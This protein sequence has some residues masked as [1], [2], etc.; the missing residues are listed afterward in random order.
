MSNSILQKV[1][2]NPFLKWAGGK[3]RLIPQ[4]Q[5]Y[6]P[7]KTEYKNYFEPFLGGGSVF[8][9]LQPKSAFLTDINQQLIETYCCVKENVEDLIK[10]LE[11]HQ[12]KHNDHKC[13]EHYYY[14]IR[15]NTYKTKI[16]RAAQLIYLN[17]TCFNGLYRVNSH[18][19]FNVPIGNYKNPKICNP[20]LLR[21]SSEALQ[22]AKI[23]YKSFDKVLNVAKNTDDFVYFDPPYHPLNETSFTAYT[24]HSFQEEE[25]RKLRDVFVELA[26]RGVKVMLSNSHSPFIEALYTDKTVF[27]S[28]NTPKI[29]KI[30]ASRMINSDITKRGKITELLITSY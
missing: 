16:E 27:S 26:D 25:Q 22:S 19:E 30:S 8:F 14:T 3:S 1:A 10:L 23:E 2:L 13:T 4:Y 11:E 21:K 9:H 24:R 29:H 18:G 12:L 6:F 5:S 15:K 28:T 7:N 17:K 20:D